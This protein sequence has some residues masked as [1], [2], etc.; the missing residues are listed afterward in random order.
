M[1][2]EAI[3]YSYSSYS[4]DPGRVK[5]L[6]LIPGTLT[7]SLSASW[8][9]GGGDMDFYMVFLRQNMQTELIRRVPKQDNKTDFEG[10]VPGQL[11]TVTVQTVA[12]TLT[13]NETINGRTRKIYSVQLTLR[14]YKKLVIFIQLAQYYTVLQSKTC[15]CF[16]PN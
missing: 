15:A 2:Y 4:A 13:N 8:S 1:H 5:N 3:H 10:L 14:Q 11:Y 12:G 9:F 16:I 7:C 6:Q